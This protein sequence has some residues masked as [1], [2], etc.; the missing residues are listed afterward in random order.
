MPSIVWPL[1][2][3]QGAVPLVT[4]SIHFITVHIGIRIL[5]CLLEVSHWDAR[6][7]RRRRRRLGAWI[8]LLCE[9]HPPLSIAR[10]HVGLVV[11]VVVSSPT[12]VA[13]RLGQ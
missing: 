3:G 12:Q 10:I 5:H 1:K 6:A 2:I 13:A 9:N 11:V 4:A 7:R 8:L